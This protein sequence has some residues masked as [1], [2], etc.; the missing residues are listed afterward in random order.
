MCTLR[1]TT[2]AVLVTGLLLSWCG[3]V[4]GGLVGHWKLDES[5]ASNGATIVD[6]SGSGHDGTL[7]VTGTPADRSAAGLV[8]GAID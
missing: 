3:A 8:G 6:S 4:R 1:K 5:P 7:T 2:V